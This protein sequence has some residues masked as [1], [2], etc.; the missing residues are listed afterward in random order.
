MKWRK[1][2]HTDQPLHPFFY[3]RR[4]RYLFNTACALS[5]VPVSRKTEDCVVFPV[6]ALSTEPFAFPR[7]KNKDPPLIKGA[8]GD[9]SET[10]HHLLGDLF[11]FFNR[12]THWMMRLICQKTVAGRE[13]ALQN[14]SSPAQRETHV[15]VR[16][17]V[18]R[19]TSQD[20]AGA[21]S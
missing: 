13:M 7:L 14:R 6:D 20:S 8:E 19:M 18:F 2:A 17:Q 9:D 3:W 4:A 15:G 1:N 5:V 11:Y 12:N 21:K 16:T 10:L